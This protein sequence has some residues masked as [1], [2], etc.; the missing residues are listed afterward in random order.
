MARSHRPPFPSAPSDPNLRR[1]GVGVAMG[2]ERP[3]RAQLVVALVSGLMLMAVPLYLW[4][5]PSA[6]ATSPQPTVS[7][8]SSPV[9]LP[10]SSTLSPPVPIDAGSL[11]VD[12]V[13]LGPVKKVRCGSTP[14]SASNEEM[15]DDLPALSKSLTDTIKSTAN[16]APKTTKG[17]TINYVL[18][19]DFTVKRVHIFPGASGDLKGPQARRATKC[20]LGALPKPDWAGIAHRYRYYAMAVLATYPSKDAHR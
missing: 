11:E 14:R 9:P 20:V 6:P 12:S 17:G 10:V 8:S 16:C 15:C 2:R 18:E 19:V 1:L 13:T 5:R 3:V 7:A 4:R